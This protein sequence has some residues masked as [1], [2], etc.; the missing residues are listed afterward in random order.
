M[1]RAG[2]K[3]KAMLKRHPNGKVKL[4]RERPPVLPHRAGFSPMEQK[5]ATAH[6]RYCLKGLITEQQHRAGEL[7]IVERTRYRAAMMSPD[8][9]RRP[10]SST[11][12]NMD[13]AHALQSFE[14]LQRL[15]G[16]HLVDLEWILLLDGML[17]D[18]SSYREGLNILKSH[19]RL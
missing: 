5:A 1:S 15:L 8:T 13:E 7:F 16:R 3:R 11:P 18:L 19:Y 4:V 12:P 9:L 2:R 10:S 6:G 14:V 17:T